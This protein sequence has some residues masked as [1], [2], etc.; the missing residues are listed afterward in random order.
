MSIRDARVAK[1]WHGWNARSVTGENRYGFRYSIHHVQEN[2]LIS[3]RNAAY[4]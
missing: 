4:C 1:D 3:K 2:V